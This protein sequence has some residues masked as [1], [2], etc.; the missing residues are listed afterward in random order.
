MGTFFNKNMNEWLS[1]VI[2]LKQEKGK[3]HFIIFGF[4]DEAV[5]FLINRIS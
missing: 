3:E 1:S 5:F 2:F 4:N